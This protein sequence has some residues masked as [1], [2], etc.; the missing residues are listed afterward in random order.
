MHSIRNS[1]HIRTHRSL[2][3]FHACLNA[4]GQQQIL[5]DLGRIHCEETRRLNRV[6]QSA[7]RASTPPSRLGV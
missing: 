5:A 7:R 1:N 2:K 6:S 4:T 3:G